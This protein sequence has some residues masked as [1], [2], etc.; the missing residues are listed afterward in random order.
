MDIAGIIIIEDTIIFEENRSAVMY[1]FLGMQESEQK[2]F[3]KTISVNQ[4]MIQCLEN[5]IIE[6]TKIKEEIDWMQVPS[7]DIEYY[8][9]KNKFDD[10]QKQIDKISDS[11]LKEAKKEIQRFGLGIKAQGIAGYKGILEGSKVSSKTYP[12]RVYTDFNADELKS[13]SEDID[14]FSSGNQ[15]FLCVIDNFI[16]IEP[17]GKEIISELVK[18]PKAKNNGVCIV[19]SSKEEKICDVTNQM[20]IG[21][22]RKDE[23][24]LDN[25]I[26]KQL[27][28]SQYKI[29]LSILSEKRKAAM[30]KV[31]NYASDNMDTAIYLASMAA[32]EGTTNYEVLNEWIELRERYFAH[33]DSAQEM[34]RI[35][36]L[37]SMLG[38]LVSEQTDLKCEPETLIDF[39]TFE[40]YDYS[41]NEFYLPPMSGDIFLIK[42]NYY[43]L[44]GQ[45]CEISLRDGKRKNPIAELVP[46]SLIA[47]KD[48]GKDKE[49]YNFE[50]LLLGKF[51][52][53]D[54][55]ISNISI[56]CTKR[57]VI[58]NEILD[59]C[60]FNCTGVA[61]IDTCSQLDVRTMN[62]MPIQW[63]QYYVSIKER[64]KGL[65]T[66]YN[67]INQKRE[68]LGFDM[69]EL[70]EDL[71]AS[72][73]NRLISII[74]FSPDGNEVIYEV[75][76]ICRIKN[77][78]LLINKLF[79]EYRGRQ[80]FN[81]IN[82]D[83]GRTSKYKL[84]QDGTELCLD[85]KTAIVLL[86]S[87]RKDNDGKRLKNRPWQVKKTDLLELINMT[88]TH[89][90]DEYLKQLETQD[91]S[92]LLDERTG[93]I[94]SKSIKYTKQSYNDELILKIQL[95]K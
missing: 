31:F 77:H 23:M 39:Q 95:C 70:L 92:I 21:F 69:T 82:M 14:L 79:L 22:V 37:S 10:I 50:K 19:L 60:A 36:L 18:N 91:E 64:I 11:M 87:S 46:I 15:Y 68:E 85:E 72:H 24:D 89:K 75:R 26:K 81:T 65:Q 94:A 83:V 41:I 52:T 62:M 30:D 47:N 51:K 20:Y 34:K 8:F 86:S 33:C 25:Q 61:S 67:S 54:N 80:A 28:M 7:R 45:E 73:N 3:L 43:M 84:M 57:V 16:G 38:N 32:E 5:I 2:I 88:K 29:M 9:K 42:N 55:I 78:T 17:R 48:M 93:Y 27:I 66:K 40:E 71:G 56:D 44:V 76:R 63:Q 49:N 6:F 13:I 53:V 4:E 35:I 12:L 74:D 90:N 1:D 59:L 58:D